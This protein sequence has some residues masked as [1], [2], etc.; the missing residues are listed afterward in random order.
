M[1]YVQSP[2]LHIEDVPM[3]PDLGRDGLDQEEYFR[4]DKPLEVAPMDFR[5][6]D[7]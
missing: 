1:L 2:L 6:F 4:H 7:S 5:V 3:L